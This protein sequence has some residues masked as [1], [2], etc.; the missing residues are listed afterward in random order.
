M[1]QCCCMRWRRIMVNDHL[2]SFP[3]AEAPSLGYFYY[4]VNHS[5][6]FWL[7]VFCK[8]TN[9]SSNVTKN[10]LLSFVKE[11]ALKFLQVR[12]GFFMCVSLSWWTR[13]FLL[14]LFLKIFKPI[15][16][17]L[18]DTLSFCEFSSWVGKFD[19]EVKRSIFPNT[20]ELS[21]F[22][23]QLHGG[24]RNPSERNSH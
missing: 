7:F 13:G 16:T 4:L 3:C 9:A 11:F 8:A 6:F 17:E 18:L 10:S 22:R 12:R 1:S 2:W 14:T 21:T 15:C 19:L 23:W 24:V 5:K 20:V